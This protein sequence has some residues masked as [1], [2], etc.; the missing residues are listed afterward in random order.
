MFVRHQS[1]ARARD[2][3]LRHDPVAKRADQRL[4]NTV[5]AF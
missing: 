1:T 3:L 5:Q 2:L 4:A